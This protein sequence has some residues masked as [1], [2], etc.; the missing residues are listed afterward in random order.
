[1]DKIISISKIVFKNLSEFFANPEIAALCQTHPITAGFAAYFGGTFQQEQFDNLTTFIHLINA[2]LKN[3]EENKV[4]R[5]FLE[6][7]DGK[8]IIGKIFRCI[9]RDNRIE[10]LIAMSNLTV[11]LFQKSKLTIDEKEIYVDI[12]DNLNILQLSILQRAMLE[13]KQRVANSGVNPHKGF[14][15]E[16][17]N[18]EYESKG[19]T[20]ALLLQSIRVLESNGLVN[21]NNA[22]AQDEN[23]THFATFFGEQFYSFVTDSN[24]K[25]NIYL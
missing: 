17:L 12:L 21:Q 25:D 19:I 4:D 23:Q 10:K 1:M 13:I 20:G 16:K 7:K 11:N 14:S 2:R 22:I 15:W 9:S 8:R 24:P 18:K 5:D 6:S 3:V